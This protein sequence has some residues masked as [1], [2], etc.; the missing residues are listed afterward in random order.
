[1]KT[2]VLYLG[3][4]IFLGISS[5]AQATI[6]DL[7]VLTIPNL[8]SPAGEE[9]YLDATYEDVTFLQKWETDGNGFEVTPSPSIG[10][11]TFDNGGNVTNDLVS[12]DLTGSSFTLRFILTKDG[13]AGS[14]N[15][16]YHLYQIEPNMGE[17]GFDLPITINNQKEISHTSFF[18]Q[19]QQVIPEPSTLILF[20]VGLLGVIGMGYLKRKKAA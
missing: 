20:A 2:L 15:T 11:Y 12:W 13:N 4:L 14:G 18:G 8:G 19:Q 10:T 16:F 7:G 17:M 1:M 3:V 5:T 9:A 6:I